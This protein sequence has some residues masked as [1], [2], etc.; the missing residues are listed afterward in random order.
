ML[1]SISEVALRQARLVL[2]WTTTVSSC[3]QLAICQLSL[4]IHSWIGATST[5]LKQWHESQLNVL[6][7]GRRRDTLLWGVRRTT[8]YRSY[9]YS[10][11]RESGFNPAF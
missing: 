7:R 4:T 10:Q 3:Y 11:T 2:G 5:T 8:I 9:D 6:S 1:V